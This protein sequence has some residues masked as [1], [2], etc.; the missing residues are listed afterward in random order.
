MSRPIWCRV[1][2]TCCCT[3]GKVFGLP[4]RTRNVR[5]L[6]DNVNLPRYQYTW[7]KNLKKTLVVQS[8]L[9]SRKSTGF[10]YNVVAQYESKNIHIIR[11]IVIIYRQGR[12]AN[13]IFERCEKIYGEKA[14]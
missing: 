7:N 9:Q 13:E 2:V 3:A 10:R 1:R 14:I 11:P 6:S 4:K 12:S 8:S 5:K